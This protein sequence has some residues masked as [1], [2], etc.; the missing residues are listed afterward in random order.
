MAI[1]ISQ[2]Y[3]VFFEETKEHLQQI[4]Q[5]L[6]KLNVGQPDIEQLNAIFRAAHSIKGGSATFGFNDITSVTHVLESLLDRLRKKDIALQSAMIDVFLQAADILNMQLDS[7][8]KGTP[9]DTNIATVI[10]KQLHALSSDAHLIIP[11]SSIKNTRN[12]VIDDGFGFFATEGKLT[13]V[14]PDS[15]DEF[16]L[17]EPVAAVEKAT[18]PK[19]A[20]K[21]TS[22][23]ISAAASD[24]RHA[25]R[26]AN[27]RRQAERATELSSIRVDV[28][29]VDQLINLVGELVI[30]KAMLLQGL[31]HAPE[32]LLQALSSNMAQ[33]ERHTRDLQELAMSVRMMPI[34]NL[35]ARFPRL[36]RDLASALKK[37]V[38]LITIGA[39][40]ELDKGLIEKIA[41]PLTHLIRNSLDHGIES[42]KA[43][44]AAGKP[45]KGTV[46][47]SA[48]HQAGSILIE[49][50][51]DGAGLNHALIINKAMKSG[52]AIPSKITDENLWDIIC[53]PGFSTADNITDISGRGVGMDVVN[54][55]ISDLSGQ[56]NVTTIAGK[57]CKISIRLPLTLAI[58]DG[59]TVAL[60]D[61]L[62]VIPLNAI[63]ETQA[64]Q[65]ENIKSIG[66]QGAMIRVRDEYLPIIAMHKALS[67]QSKIT[68]VTQGMLVIVE[69]H[70]KKAALLF[71]S[72]V[73]QQQV[74]IKSLEANFRKINGISGATILGDG[75]VALIID[76]PSI[77]KLGQAMASNEQTIAKPV[78]Q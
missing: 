68:D 50:S 2:F 54:R 51:D 3:Q 59:M 1:D 60:G 52:I 9:A 63:V 76:A 31:S 34:S 22:E 47:L 23:P 48:M 13:E 10:I 27:D 26:R 62:F 46:T 43:R 11:K 65:Q 70:G 75:T 67:I 15:D 44:K 57:G 37:D 77:I 28:A 45:E 64:A 18:A 6:L 58:L 8:I 21:I 56:V 36:V 32:A 14:T 38:E 24:N 12:N 55:N 30:T 29:K 25:D 78:K 74:V 73:G 61:N 41:D 19:I 49:V 69:A 40:T 39:D 7:H 53:T 16:G 35:F 71:D 20:A 42:P 5:L 4:E 66:N 33:L 72:L 17:F